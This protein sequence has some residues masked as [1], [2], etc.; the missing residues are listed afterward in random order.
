MLSFGGFNLLLDVALQVLAMRHRATLLLAAPSVHLYQAEN[1]P[2]NLTSSTHADVTVP[3]VLEE[4]F[5]LPARR[6]AAIRVIALAR[7]DQGLEKELQRVFPGPTFLI[8][9]LNASGIA[10]LGMH[11]PSDHVS[12]HVVRVLD[13]SVT[14]FTEVVI[15]IRTLVALV[16][17]TTEDIL[18]AVA[19]SVQMRRCVRIDKVV[20]DHHRRK[21]ARENSRVRYRLQT[22]DSG[23]PPRI[24]VGMR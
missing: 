15:A 10:R 19:A 17:D 6:L 22:G 9:A 8:E 20:E 1:S 16:S 4:L 24:L 18:L 7:M 13:T 3:P 5:H 23:D 11:A 21:Y 2:A 14:A 12:G